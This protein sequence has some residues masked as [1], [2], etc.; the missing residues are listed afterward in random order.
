MHVV[1]SSDLKLNQRL[2]RNL[3]QR[4]AIHLFQLSVALSLLTVCVWPRQHG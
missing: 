1:V 3:E 2:S 4:A